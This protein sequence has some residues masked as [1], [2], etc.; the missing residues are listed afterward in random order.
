MWDPRL[1][2][3]I[4]LTRYRDTINY[5]GYYRETMRS[6]INGIGMGDYLAMRVLANKSGKVWGVRINCIGN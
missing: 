6:M 5:L 4:T 2:M 1:L 3:D